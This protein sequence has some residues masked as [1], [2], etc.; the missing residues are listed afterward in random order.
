MTPRTRRRSPVGRKPAL[1]QA[2]G[3]ARGSQHLVRGCSFRPV[4]G[5]PGPAP[6]RPPSTSELTPRL[7][8]NPA[9][10]AFSAKDDPQERGFRPPA[11]RSLLRVPQ[12]PAGRGCPSVCLRRPPAPAAAA[13]LPFFLRQPRWSTGYG[14]PAGTRPRH[15]RRPRPGMACLAPGTSQCGGGAPGT[16]PRRPSRTG[17]PGG[18]ARTCA[19]GTAEGREE[20]GVGGTA[21]GR[22]PTTFPTASEGTPA[23]P[24][25]GS[26]QGRSVVGFSCAGGEAEA[27][28]QTAQPTSS[29]SAGTRGSGP[30]CS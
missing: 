14:G 21:P 7:P 22:G 18:P 10:P 9:G 29:W 24:S 5:A 16:G 26:R 17:G 2:P 27:R 28:S 25:L 23:L 1:P 30:F 12:V 3:C 15:P 19:A 8:A 13:V 6:T 20:E 4:P 11:T